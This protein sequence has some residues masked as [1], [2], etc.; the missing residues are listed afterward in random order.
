LTTTRRS[1][2]CGWDRRPAPSCILIWMARVLGHEGAS[3]L[4]AEKWTHAIDTTCWDFRGRV[5]LDRL[6]G[7]RRLDSGVLASSTSSH[8]PLQPGKMRRFDQGP[9]S[10]SP[11]ARINQEKRTGY[12]SLPSR[13]WATTAWHDKKR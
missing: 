5:R 2:S 8:V 4:D 11:G 3:R 12:V 10:L 1:C 7:V 9:A 6:V 13:C